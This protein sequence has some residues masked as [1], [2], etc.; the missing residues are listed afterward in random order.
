MSYFSRDD[1][2]SNRKDAIAPILPMIHN[3]HC[4]SG[5]R[6]RYELAGMQGSSERLESSENR[7]NITKSASDV[8]L[9]LS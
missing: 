7:G 3:G 5:V 8:V 6:T 9:Q 4:A 2:L 1:S